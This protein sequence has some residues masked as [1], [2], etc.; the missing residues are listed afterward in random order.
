M[1]KI[2]DSRCAHPDCEKRRHAQ[3]DMCPQH[4]TE[5]RLREQAQRAGAQVAKNQ[6]GTL[7]VVGGSPK[8]VKRGKNVRSIVELRSWIRKADKDAEKRFSGQLAVAESLAV[9]IDNDNT[10]NASTYRALLDNIYK[11]IDTI[12]G[13]E[14]LDIIA[15]MQRMIDDNAEARIKKGWG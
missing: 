11:R 8:R 12:Y 6:D 3:S 1:T 13:T 4:I 2:K 5:R 15:R 7:T 9:E 10:S 14:N